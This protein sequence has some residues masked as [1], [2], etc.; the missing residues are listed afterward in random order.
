MT[1]HATD[2]EA[3]TVRV[4]PQVS[5]SAARYH[6]LTYGKTYAQALCSSIRT[7]RTVQAKGKD[8]HGSEMPWEKILQRIHD[9]EFRTCQR[10]IKKRS[11]TCMHAASHW[12]RATKQKRLP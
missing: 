2:C 3:W 6:M 12:S 1:R 10:N 4:L 11:Q 8:R 7:I 9:R 5:A